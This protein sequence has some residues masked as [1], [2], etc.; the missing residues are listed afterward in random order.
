[1]S[2]INKENNASYNFKAPSIAEDADKKIE[3]VFPTSEVVSPTITSNAASAPVRREKTIVKLGT[4]SA[5]TTLTL[6]PEQENLNIGAVVAVN[7]TSDSTAR[8]IT[9]KVGEDTVATLS[10]TA[11]TK[12]TKQ[13]MWDGEGFLAV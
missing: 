11:S 3:P 7:W 1:M 10:G 9:V 8:A 6:V 5:A 4:V 12:V 13:L 2:K